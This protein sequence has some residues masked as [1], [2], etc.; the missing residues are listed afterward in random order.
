VPAKQIYSSAEAT[1][2]WLADQ[3]IKTVY[4]IGEEGLLHALRTHGIR[5]SDKHHAKHVIV[6]LDRKLTYEHL[7]IAC[8]LI[9]AGAQFIGTNPD[10]SYPVEDGFAPECGAVLGAVQGATGKKPMIIGKPAVIIFKQAAARLK[11]PLRN[12]TMIGDR[13]D[14]DIIGAKRAGAKSIL[15]LTGHCTRA[16]LRHSKV[17]PDRVVSNLSELKI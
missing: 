11:L 9:G 14:T 1:A 16:H 12:L 8:R 10:P 7:K 3:K 6:G 17:R 13:L 15:V 4:A 2:Q 5:V